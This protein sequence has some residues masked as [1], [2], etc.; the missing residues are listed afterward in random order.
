MSFETPNL[1]PALPEIF[2]LGMACVV[3]LANVYR[4]DPE[5]FLTY[6]LT[7][8]TMIGALILTVTLHSATPEMT[9]S[10]SYIKDAMS[11][12]LKV[13]IYLVTF[14]ALLYSRKYL[15]ARD[16]NRGE[17][18]VLAIFAVLGMMVMVSAYSMLVLYVG[19]ELLALSLYA[20]V[21]LNRDSSVS[22]EAAMK[23]FVL[24]AL[25]SGLL[26]YGM[27]LFYGVTGSLNMTDMAQ[28]LNMGTDKEIVLRLAL[29]FVVIG[30][31]FKLGLVPFHMWVPDVYHGAPTSV[32]LFL[33][34]VPKI[35]AFGMVMRLLVEG[36][37]GMHVD[38]QGMLIVL[39]VLSIVVGNVVAIAQANLKRMLA[40]STIS[41]M[42]F[43]VLGVLTGTADGYSSSM[44]Y[45]LVYAIMGLGG[46]GMIILLSRAGFEADQLDDFKGL[47]ERSP[48][49]AFMMLILMFSMA[50]IPPTVGFFAKLAVL[51]AAVSVGLIW[52][53]VI[54]V[55]FSVVGAFYYLRI[56]KLMYFDKPVDTAPIESS[57][58]M[59]ATLSANGIIVLLLGIYPSSL[60][61]LCYSAL[62]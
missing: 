15:K 25:A 27:S 48:W 62:Q 6:L 3:L 14:V 34:T 44:F 47:N 45:T 30:L 35:A 8:V 43:L 42:G 5:C 20:M 7:Q 46:F 36:F 53:V 38:W 22:T 61:A 10:N 37:G 31:A 21:A 28:S 55:L 39:A 4:R 1:I 40:Y 18:Y 19:L 49:M 57:F 50:G 11:D 2:V 23:Y 12:I 41:H 58:D 29:V 59:K 9:F 16:L 24:G 60:M 52:L 13:F 32:T 51:Q 54:A 26:L 17:Y 33:G 56:V